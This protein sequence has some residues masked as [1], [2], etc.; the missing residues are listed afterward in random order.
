MQSVR[1]LRIGGP[2][3]SSRP[4][5]LEEFVM[6]SGSARRSFRVRDE[7]AATIR[8]SVNVMVEYDCEPM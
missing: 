6:V 2:S 5:E 7:L 1:L 4:Y 3:A 8:V